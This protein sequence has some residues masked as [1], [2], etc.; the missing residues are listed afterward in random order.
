MNYAETMPCFRWTFRLVLLTLIISC[1]EI[2][3]FRCAA[4]D[5]RE[6]VPD[7]KKVSQ[8]ISQLDSP[9]RAERVQAERSLIQLGE[10]A[11]PAL[12]EFPTDDPVIA[13]H[14]DRIRLAIR[15]TAATETLEGT[16]FSFEASQGIGIQEFIRNLTEATGN[17]VV[18]DPPSLSRRIQFHGDDIP[19][20][21]V[22]DDVCLHNDL[23]W[24]TSSQS[25]VLSTSERTRYD[26]ADYVKCV[27]I[28][29]TVQRQRQGFRQ[30]RRG[31]LIRVE[32]RLDVEPQV[33]PFFAQV[34]DRDFELSNETLTATP[35]NPDAGHELL[36]RGG[37]TAVFTV[38]FQT[39]SETIEFPVNASG[40]ITLFCAARREP[41]TVALNSREQ[42][43]DNRVRLEGISRTP[44]ETIVRLSVQLPHNAD[45]L[46]SHRLGL[47]HRDVKLHQNDGQV[48]SPTRIELLSRRGLLHSLEVRFPTGAEA[49]HLTY[50]MP[51]LL[52]FLPVP[53]EIHGLERN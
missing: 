35:F 22:I 36:F 7:E 17:E 14:L 41:I 1:A 11:I 53:F 10:Q 31:Q 34:F 25:V 33:V 29:G 39:N 38:D 6:S 52:T 50:G 46:R 28:G 49:T 30:R 16:R 40:F 43:P 18:T 45:E 37:R 9:S 26:V 8:L 19:F 13:I 44:D 5:D 23:G 47:L 4:D 42:T 2:N 21:Q 51:E 15:K 27:R 20:W 3:E 12:E 24:R 32:F 48:T